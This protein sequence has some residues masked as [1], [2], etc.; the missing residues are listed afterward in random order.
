MIRDFFQIYTADLRNHGDSPHASTHD[1]FGMTADIHAFMQSNSIP[2]ICAMGHSMGGRAV[3]HFAL[4]Y[5]CI[6][7]EKLDLV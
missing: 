1:S 5:V 7:R 2:K 6:N 4:S 3:M